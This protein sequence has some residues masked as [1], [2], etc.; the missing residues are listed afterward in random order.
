VGTFTWCVQHARAPHP[1]A[2][3]Q[4]AR[5]TPA[6]TSPR[7]APLRRCRRAAA[8]TPQVPRT[9]TK[10]SCASSCAPSRIVL[11]MR[12]RFCKMGLA[13][14]ALL[15]GPLAGRA[16]V[17]SFSS[18]HTRQKPAGGGG[19]RGCVWG[20]G[21]GPGRGRAAA[22]WGS[23]CRRTA[24]ATGPAAARWQK[25]CGGGGAVAAPWAPTCSRAALAVLPGQQEGGERPG[26]QQALQHAVGVAGVAVVHQPG[27][28]GGDGRAAPV[29]QE[30]GVGVQHQLGRRCHLV[31]RLS[32]RRPAAGRRWLLRAA[33]AA[34]RGP[35]ALGRLAQPLAGI[36]VLGPA[37]LLAVARAAGRSTGG[38]G[39]GGQGG[40]GG[41]QAGA[42]KRGRAS[43]AGRGRSVVSR[44]QV[45]PAPVG[46][47]MGGG[48][49]RTS[50]WRSCSGRTAAWWACRTQRSWC[51]LAP[52]R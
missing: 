36:L 15:V 17:A 33:A 24:A 52:C 45:P 14:S 16:L 29:L 35:L 12:R 18:S 7:A 1:A 9:C 2:L 51:C 28:A 32:G 34:L 23:R 39:G 25:D 10:N 21:P 13:D 11:L 44:G 6:A 19:S 8:T 46:G 38:G 3:L 42:G 30:A 43:G 41:W 22:R 37:R 26:G 48:E 50:T 27:G 4:Q 47:K 40:E 5:P 20:G 49:L 31:L